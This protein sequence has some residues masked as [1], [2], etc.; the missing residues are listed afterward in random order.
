MAARK[1][2]TFDHLAIERAAYSMIDNHGRFA[3]EIAMK[4]ARN[5]GDEALDA[6]RTW[7]RIVSIICQMQEHALS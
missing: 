1:Q 3:A 6:R 4:R 7:E 2:K 5:L